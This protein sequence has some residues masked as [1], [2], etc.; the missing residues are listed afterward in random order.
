MD[1][2]TKSREQ[3][4][5]TS[6]W[7]GFAGSTA[8]WIVLGI[9][10][11]L[12]TWF[13]CFGREQ[14][15]GASFEPEFKWIFAICTLALFATAMVAGMVSFRNWRKLSRERHLSEAEG[16]GRQE[17]MALIGVFISFTLGMGIVWLG[18]PILIIDLC[19]RAR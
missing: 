13:A 4:S 11:L 14:Y 5:P 17:Y 3:V 2:D 9:A 16:R 15:G 8:A 19:V 7:F 6:L 10:D 12:I 1:V 18:I